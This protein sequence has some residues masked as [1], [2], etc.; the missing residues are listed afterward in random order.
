MAVQVSVNGFSVNYQIEGPE[1]APCVTFSNSLACDLGMWDEQAARL[2]DRYR[3]LR[4]DVRGHG[5]SEAVKGPY[6][7][8]MLISDVVGL[9]D[10]LGIDRSHWVGLSLGGMKGFGLA[11]AHPERLIS[12]S[13]CDSQSDAPEGYADYFSE[14]IRITREEGMEG[15]VE[16]TINRWFLDE[17]L[18]PELPVIDKLRA[19][20][21]NTSPTGHIGCCQ[22]IR[23]LGYGPRLSEIRVPTQ[24]VGGEGDVGA[25][26][27]AMAKIAAAI[28]GARHV[29]IEKAGHISNVE[30]PKVFNRVL[31][32]WLS[33]H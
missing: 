24:I 23:E 7:L 29:V 8:D 27:E 18:D 30:N 19:M 15:L 32:D 9:W 10:A 16:H 28:P 13:C 31:E 33:T 26:P 17:S 20:I 21:R 1:D 2:A 6:T 11:L 5:E 12:M 4:Y 3:V 22:A 25:P 14:R